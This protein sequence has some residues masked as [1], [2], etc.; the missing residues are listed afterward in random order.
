MTSNFSNTS[1]K[2]LLAP[3]THI[4]S[5]QNCDVLTHLHHLCQSKLEDCQSDHHLD[6]LL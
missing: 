6:K 1:V 5:D 2:V 4:G 3:L